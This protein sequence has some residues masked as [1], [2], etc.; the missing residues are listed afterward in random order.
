VKLILRILKLHI[1]WSC[2]NIAA[3]QSTNAIIKRTYCEEGNEK[4][5]SVNCN[6]FSSCYDFW[7]QTFNGL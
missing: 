7:L 3:H 2:K 5:C 1:L 4:K 6:W